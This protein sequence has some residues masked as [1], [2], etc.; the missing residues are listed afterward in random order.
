MTVR[1]K[2]LMILSGL[3]LVVA[4]VG[5]IAIT[6]AMMPRSSQGILKVARAAREAGR[7]QD[8]EIYYKQAL[9]AEPR[10]ATTHEDFAGMYRRLDAQAD[11]EKRTALRAERLQHL[12]QAVKFDKAAKGPRRDLLRDAMDQDL[13]ADSVYWAKEML[14]VAPDDLDAHYVLAAE[15]LEERPPNVP[16]VKRHLEVLEKG[17]APAVRRLWIRARLADLAGDEPARAAALAEA[18]ALPTRRG[19]GRPGRPVRPAAADGPG[20]PVRVRVAGARRPGRAALRAGQGAG[21]ARG[22]AAGA[23]RP[24]AGP[25]GADPVVSDGPLGQAAARGPE[26]HRRGWSTPSRSIWRRVFQQALADGRQPDL[27]T[28]FSY[29]VHLRL[30]RQPDRCL[31]IV[32]RAL[33]SPQASKRTSVYR[34]LDLHKVAVDMI[35]AKTEDAGRFD[36]AM[37]HVQALLE[38]PEPAV[39]GARPHGRRLDRPRPLGDRPRDDRRR[40]RPGRPAVPGQAPRQRTESPQARRR[41]PP[42]RRRGPG[43]VRR[44]PGADPG[45]EPRPPVPPD[46]PAARQPGPAVSDLGG[47][48][49]PAGRLSRG[50]RADRAVDAPSGRPGRACR[51]S[52]KGR[53]TSSAA[54]CTRPA[55]ARRT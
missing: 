39:P 38:S 47:L 13:P 22:P 3:F 14:N 37:P 54:S 41:R 42:R 2:P 49:D 31:E 6:A 48:D 46:R 11:A 36:K 44:R 51:A 12:A 29:A 30:R 25:A 15:T 45:A 24:P 26:G 27:Q 23:G 40:G 9:Q 35:L 1:W 52:W 21:Q 28:Y 18:Q 53:S 19:R 8:A 10:N 5:V 32:D 43:Q 33:K 50:G 34:V 7:F 17:K 4:L 16:E 20:G 55:A